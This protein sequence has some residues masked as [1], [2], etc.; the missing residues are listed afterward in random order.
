MVVQYPSIIISIGGNFFAFGKM[1]EK[2]LLI[3]L[4]LIK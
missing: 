1:Q 3:A 4:N 2:Y